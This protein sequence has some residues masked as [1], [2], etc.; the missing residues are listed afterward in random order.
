MIRDVRL[1][2]KNL[3]RADQSWPAGHAPEMATDLREILARDI[4]TGKWSRLL[5]M[6]VPYRLVVIE[7]TPLLYKTKT[8]L[9]GFSPQLYRPS[10]RRLSAKLVPTFADRECRMV[11][12]TDLHG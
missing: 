1:S 6:K 10:H 12:A 7:N 2:M 5:L 3:L 11:S 9:R 4:T 8:K